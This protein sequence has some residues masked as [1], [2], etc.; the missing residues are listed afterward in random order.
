MNLEVNLDIFEFEQFA[1]YVHVK[2]F[3]LN[4]VLQQ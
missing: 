2:K 3:C 1:R 4:V